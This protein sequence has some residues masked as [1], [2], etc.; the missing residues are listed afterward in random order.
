MKK[1]LI[2]LLFAANFLLAIPLTLSEYI[3]KNPSWN[4]S[5]RPSLSYITLRCGVLFEQISELYK[6]NVE[7]QETYKIAP[8]D[9]IN[10]FRASSDIYKTSCINY[11]CIKV[12]KKDSQ[13][14]VKKWALIYKKE[15]M[16]NINNNDEMMHGDI[17]DDFST[18]KIKVKPILK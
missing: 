5:N 4:S 1:L 16:N 11:D 2:L 7:E 14:K 10:F 8:T 13:E 9:A 18:C 15:L 6:N 3:A 12:E 17:K